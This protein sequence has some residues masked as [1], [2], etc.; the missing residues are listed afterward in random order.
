MIDCSNF[1]SSS[2]RERGLAD[3]TLDRDILKLN[4]CWKMESLRFLD[5]G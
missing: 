5:G 1:S 2:V 3:D 4:W